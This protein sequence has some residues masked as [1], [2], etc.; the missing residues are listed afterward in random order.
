MTAVFSS[1]IWSFL[2]GGRHV[3][4]IYS[5]TL[6]MLPKY[7]I[8]LR[9][10][11][12][13]SWRFLQDRYYL[14]A[15]NSGLN[16]FIFHWFISLDTNSNNVDKS[17]I[18]STVSLLMDQNSLMMRLKMVSILKTVFMKTISGFYDRPIIYHPENCLSLQKIVFAVN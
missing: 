10:N 4:L 16:H 13:Y 7:L 1:E 11:L 15:S 14:G 3:R 17:R 8:L 9:R 2:S 5:D 6:L 18:A 12:I